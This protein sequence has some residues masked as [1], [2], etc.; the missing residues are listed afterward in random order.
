MKRLALQTY[1]AI[2][3]NRET[4]LALGKHL[5]FKL[6]KKVMAKFQK[7]KASFVEITCSMIKSCTLLT[8]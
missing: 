5:K 7:L 8:F 6:K 3:I 1:I 2:V 4:N